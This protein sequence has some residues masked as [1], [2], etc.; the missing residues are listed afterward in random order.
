MKLHWGFV[1]LVFIAAFVAG[2]YFGGVA[3]VRSRL[4][5]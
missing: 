3:G 5:V 4:G 1:V 2:G